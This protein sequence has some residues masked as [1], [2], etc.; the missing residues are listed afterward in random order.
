MIRSVVVG[1]ALLLP[2]PLWGQADSTARTDSLAAK[3]YQFTIDVGVLE[4]G[5]AYGQ[6]VAFGRLSLGA[7]VWVA[8]QPSETFD[9]SFF[10]PRGVELFARYQISRYAQAEVGPSFLRYAYA[11]D[12]SRCTGSFLGVHGAALVGGHRFL[13]GPT[14][15]YGRVTGGPDPAE[16]GFVYGLQM[17]ILFGWE[18]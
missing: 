6:R 9:R 16:T 11:D 14:I 5:L 17:R 3:R 7:G 13:F 10:E 18:Q 4:L 12:C 2:G 1:I 15:R 8:W